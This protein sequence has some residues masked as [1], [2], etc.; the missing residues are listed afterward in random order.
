MI[1]RI[2]Y[3]F[4]RI[5]PHDAPTWRE[6][7]VLAD[8]LAISLPDLERLLQASEAKEVSES[9]TAAPAHWTGAHREVKEPDWDAIF[10]GVD[11]CDAD[12]VLTARRL[13]KNVDGRSYAREFYVQG[14]QRAGLTEIGEY[15]CAIQSDDR[16]NVFSFMDVIKHLPPPSKR[17]QSVRNELKKAALSLRSEE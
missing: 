15:L 3:R 6:L 14:C 7:K 17:L 2:A 13:L 8:S 16:F 5:Q 4:L 1:L 10:S 12:S 9:V 11:L